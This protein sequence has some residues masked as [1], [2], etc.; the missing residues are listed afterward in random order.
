MTMVRRSPSNHCQVGA[1]GAALEI[2]NVAWKTRKTPYHGGSDVVR[3][4]ALHGL[5]VSVEDCL[6]RSLREALVC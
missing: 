4:P 2:F 3:G 1:D 5:R 6:C